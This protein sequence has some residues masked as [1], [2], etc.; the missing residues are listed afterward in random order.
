MAQRETREIVYRD[1]NPVAVILDI[2]EYRE[3][4]ER[5]EDLE[6]L[7]AL[8]QMRARGPKTRPLEEFLGAPT[9]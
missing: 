5:L 9:C 3:S 2:E 1:G 6:D 8:D 7:A 4:L